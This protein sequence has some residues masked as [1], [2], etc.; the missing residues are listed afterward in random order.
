MT[1]TSSSSKSVR[2]DAER[3]VP[4]STSSLEGGSPG[5]RSTSAEKRADPPERCE[6]CKPTGF[7]KNS[8]GDV[9]EGLVLLGHAEEL[10]ALIA[11]E[12][13]ENARLR[14]ELA[15][16]EHLIRWVRDQHRG[17]FLQVQ[18]E[19]ESWIR[20]ANRI[21]ASSEESKEKGP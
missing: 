11:K 9:V 16:A 21:L 2:P 4:E 18:G 17:R 10:H 13:A 12:K 20:E 6:R 5:T 3:A 7:V 19:E 8:S 14:S 15:E 1:P